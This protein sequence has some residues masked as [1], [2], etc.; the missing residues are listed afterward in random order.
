MKILI[1]SHAAG[2]PEIGPNMRTYYLGRHLVK[3]GNTVSV[4]GSGNFHKYRVSPLAGG[5]YTTG[6]SDGIEYHWLP[7]F[8][9]KKRNYQQVVN[10]LDF[11]Y[12]LWRFRKRWLAMQPDIVLV[13]SPPPFGI[14]VG[15]YLAQ[16]CGSRLIFEVRDLWPELIQE[17]GDFSKNHPYMRLI[18]KTVNVAYRAADGIV[19]VKPGDLSHIQEKYNIKGRTAF[20]PNGYDHTAILD[21][22]FMHPVFQKESF[23]IIYTGALSSYYAIEYLLLAAEKL[24]ATH[25]DVEIIIAGDGN[26]RPT[27]E[28]LKKEK[29]LNNVTF[30][31]FLP[32]K[33]MLS[34]IRQS[35]VAFLGLRN[36][37]ANQNGISTNKLYEYMYA[38]IPVI[39]S[40][41]TDYDLVK[42]I[43]C[44]LSIPPESTDAIY[45]AVV[46][47]YETS[48]TD[49]KI[50]GQKGYDCLMTRH[51]FTEIAK[52]YVELMETLK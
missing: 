40:Y 29:S 43:G 32:K 48:V 25:P 31:G 45:S 44:G 33:Y 34:I 46:Q 22:T 50:M 21:E 4:V 2:T 49:R 20:I 7:T 27:Y 47:L 39:A 3:M 51:T 17:L 52:K 35:N 18:Q 23:K 16:K 12:Q 14:F 5:K 30:L 24:Q 28:T 9:Y 15:K 42:E 6:K 37:K 10:Q 1:V 41:N 38:K 11:A 13:S 26:D 19:S 8:P 36:T